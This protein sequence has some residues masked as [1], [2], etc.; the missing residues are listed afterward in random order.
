[1]GYTQPEPLRG[2]HEIAAFC[3]GDS[4]LDSWLHRHARQAEATD[5]AKTFVT[6][7]D[8]KTVVGYYALAI[9]QV[10]S[11]DASA[12]LLKGQPANSPVSVL[13]LAR[14]AV[15][16]KHQGNG[17]G[18]SLVED[19]LLQCSVVS[20][21]VGVRALTVYAYPEANAF[22]DQFGFEESPTD[23]L[24]R[25]LLTKDLRLFLEELGVR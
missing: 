4:E 7:S 19:A 10:Q 15:D 17:V 12:R 6:T 11:E 16:R 1:M 2:K 24:H 5:S 13:H 9:N 20:E 21:R 3:C 25:I 18:S 8:G 14:L 22:Y 23:P